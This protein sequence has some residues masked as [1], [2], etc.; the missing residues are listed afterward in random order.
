MSL[1]RPTQ[2]IL[3]WGA[4]ACLLAT[5]S[6]AEAA[7]ATAPWKLAGQ[8]DFHYGSHVQVSGGAATG[9]R[10]E[11]KLFYT[12]DHRWWAALGNSAGSDGAGVY[13]YELVG[14]VWTER[15]E[16]P[17][18]DPWMKADALFETGNST[19]YLTLRDQRSASDNPRQ[20]TLYR[21][22]YLGGG[23]WD[24]ASGPTSV[25]T[26][27]PEVLTIA[28]DSQDRLWVTFEDAGYIRVLNT[29]PGSTSFSPLARLPLPAKVATDDVAAIRTF[30]GPDGPA[31]G[32]MW[33]DQIDGTFGFAWRDDDD[34]TGP[35]NSGVAPSWHVETAYG[36]GVAGCGTS[37]DGSTERCGD[38]HISLAA[39]GA[40]VYAAV[41]TS[42]N[43][44][45]DANPSDPL[46][47]LL[48]RSPG[49]TWQ[50]FEVSPV[51]EN[52]SRPIVVLNPVLD[53]LHVWANYKGVHVWESALSAP[54]FSGANRARWTAGGTGNPTSTKQLVTPASGA[55]VETSHRRRTEYHHNEFLPLPQ[56]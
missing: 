50:S 53:R 11:T 33:S 49:G 5:S 22:A 17:G 44:G 2:R 13:L 34:P 30:T 51:A 28:R 38:D 29:Q 48:R 31:L 6:G 25:T 45:S 19:L 20:S 41:K 4:L 15:F 23:L 32:V 35:L 42:L 55:V 16:L 7:L 27:N 10:S 46:I 39:D 37:G 56:G 1:A 9:E 12:P 36:D 40:R 21:F 8:L 14:H 18:S 47:V 43:D 54:A 3:L 26:K 24:H 52:A